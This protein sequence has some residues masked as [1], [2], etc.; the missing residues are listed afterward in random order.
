[1][2][3]VY[4]ERI[5][6][7]G[8]R[9]GSAPRQPRGATEAQQD[10]PPRLNIVLDEN[11]PGVEAQREPSAHMATDDIPQQGDVPCDENGFP[12]SPLRDQE[13]LWFV[14]AADLYRPL[15]KAARLARSSG[16]VLLF[17]GVCTALLGVLGSD[18][19]TGVIGLIV[20]TLGGMERSA[21]TDLA[22]AKPSALPRL[23][24]NQGIVLALIVV[25]SWMTVRSLDT[26]TVRAMSLSNEAVSQLPAEMQGLARSMQSAS[27]RLTEGLFIVIVG[28]SLIFQG[29]LAAYYLTR[30]RK[31][32]RFY[33]ELPPWV[34]EIVTTVALR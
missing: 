11:P 3:D 30:R 16:M 15:S 20:A 32:Q 7:V 2:K 5:A 27:S 25:S 6:G 19:V 24:L 23:A 13:D 14:Q 21:A 4:F 8:A 12:V 34:C 26:E 22:Q 17:A 28:L 1:M 33:E 31:L 29:G 9:E 10:E 18:M